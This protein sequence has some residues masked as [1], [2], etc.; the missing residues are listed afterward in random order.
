MTRE[1]WQ[2]VPGVFLEAADVMTVV[3]DG[4]RL[5]FY[6]KIWMNIRN[7]NSSLLLLMLNASTLAIPFSLKQPE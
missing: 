6:S 4:F 1:A 7:V 3:M 5:V 2:V